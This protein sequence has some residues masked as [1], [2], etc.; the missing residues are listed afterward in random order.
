MYH[1]HFF[2]WFISDTGWA[3]GL[4]RERH[5]APFS[6]GK[7]L[8]VPAPDQPRPERR[9]R[10]QRLAP[11]AVR[12][13]SPLQPP[14]GPPFLAATDGSR[15]CRS[16]PS[17]C[18]SSCPSSFFF[19]VRPSLYLSLTIPFCFCFFFFFSSVLVAHR[20]HRMPAPVCPIDVLGGLEQACAAQT[21]SVFIMIKLIR[22]EEKWWVRA[23]AEDHQHPVEA[24]EREG[25]FV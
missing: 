11:R 16:T 21:G 4:G 12:A 15:P 5:H 20:C 1:Y 22:G 14:V 19:L 17:S 25:L 18:S 8:L 13:V 24:K 6:D 23:K 3:S 10:Q 7:V 9:R 2:A